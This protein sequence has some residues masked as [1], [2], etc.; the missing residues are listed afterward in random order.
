VC[1]GQ[2]FADDFAQFA[3]STQPPHD[4]VGYVDEAEQMLISKFLRRQES[5]HKRRQ[6]PAQMGS[7]DAN[8]SSL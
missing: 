6:G 2:V 8:A 5:M 1:H 4:G 7:P 3:Y